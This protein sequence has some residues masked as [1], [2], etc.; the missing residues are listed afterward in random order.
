[1]LKFP[2]EVMPPLAV[3]A[4][5]AVTAPVPKSTAPVPKST[6]PE[7]TVRPLLAV[8]NPLTVSVLLAVTAPVK[9]VA[10]VT[11]SVPA[12]SVFPEPS[13]VKLVFSTHSEP[14]QRNVALAVVPSATSPISPA[15]NFSHVPEL[16][17]LSYCHT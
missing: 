8:S 5:S 14:L 1:M 10:P 7:D 13:A 17:S 16:A 4:P 6:A 12:T 2:V 11:S 15:A 9:V 3:I